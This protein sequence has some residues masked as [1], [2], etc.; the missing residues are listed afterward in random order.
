MTYEALIKS[1]RERLDSQGILD[2]SVDAF[3]LLEKATGV[4]GAAFYARLGEEVPNDEVARFEELLSRRLNR[5]PLQ[6]IIGKAFFYGR[7]I[8][9]DGNELI[10]RPDTEVLVENLLE[11]TKNEGNL[12][13]LDLCTGSGCVAIAIKAVRSDFEI[14][15][16]DFSEAAL[17]CAKKNAVHNGVAIDFR[18]GDL[19]AAVSGECFDAIVSNPPY[20]RTADIN[21]LMPEVR[22]YDPVLAL[23]GGS[24]GL[25]VYRR[26]AE[27]AQEHLTEKGLLLLEIGEDQAKDVTLLLESA[28]FINVTVCKDYAD[29]DRVVIGRKG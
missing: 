17:S 26:I 16:T 19:F 22:D 11:L 2:S 20:I 10:P 28:G 5:E 9:V 24:D 3:Y 6:L 14:T 21:E 29:H 25:E 27:Q 1:A 12:K 23:D 15:A 8:L 18:S 13:L 4:N 7:E